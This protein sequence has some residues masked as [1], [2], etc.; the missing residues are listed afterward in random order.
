MRST[1]LGTLALGLGLVGTAPAQSPSDVFTAGRFREHV[2]Y[3][4]SDDLDGRATGTPGARKAAAY[5][6]EEFTRLGLEPAGDDGTFYQDFRLDDGT[7]ARNVLAR[8]PGRGKSA[9]ETVIVSAHY[10]HLGHH[11]E[12]PTEDGDTLCNGADD[13][14]SGVAAVLMIAEDLAAKGARD[15]ADRRAV[16]FAAFDAEERGLCGSSYLADHPVKPAEPPV[17]IVNFD[18][19]GRLRRGK[20]YAGDAPSCSVLVEELARLETEL[21]QPI[22]TRFGGVARSDQAP[23]L[24]RGIPS[25]HFNTG[26]YPEYHSPADELA[27]LDLPGGAAVARVGGRLVRTLAARPGVLPFHAL[28]PTYD[29][30][31]ALSLVRRL[32][33][34][35]NLRAQDGRRLQVLFVA[36]GSPAARCGMKAGDQ[37][38][39]V[40]GLEIER[41][42]DAVALVPQ[43]RLEDGVRVTVVRAGRELEVILPPDVFVRLSGPEVKAVKDD[44]YE[45]TF[46]YTPELGESPR[47]VAVAGSFNAWSSTA[48]PMNGPDAQ[49][50]FTVRLVLPRGTYQYRFVLD[51]HL[52]QTDTANLHQAGPDHNSVVWAGPRP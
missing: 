35:P 7:P 40:N 20:L 8:W 51:G 3:L 37:L 43:L 38:A 21:G 31:H 44:R 19:I 50:R 15:E 14:A 48:L 10:D 41:V 29:V 1:L 24:A 23:F 36:P 11:P 2:A 30:Q 32:G 17:A 33:V 13:N 49:G 25:V 46:H 22:E 52:W 45:L 26:L 16:V 5:I 12:K 6:A 9:G 4:A 28:D 42:E 34:V 18:M 39:A 47:T 27:T